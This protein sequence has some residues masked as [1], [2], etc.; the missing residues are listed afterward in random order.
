MIA[1]LLDARGDCA[2]QGP[3]ECRSH[4]ETRCGDVVHE[5]SNFASGITQHVVIIADSIPKKLVVS[6]GRY[7]HGGGLSG[8]EGA[9][10][11]RGN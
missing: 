5:V 11:R 7:F 6:L 4:D 3:N 8:K 10:R 2:W 9:S 1:A